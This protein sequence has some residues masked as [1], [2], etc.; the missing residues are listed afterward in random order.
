MKLYDA[1]K[2][3]ETEEGWPYEMEIRRAKWPKSKKVSI[4][5]QLSGICFVNIEIDGMLEYFYWTPDV[6]DI[7]ADD[8]EVIYTTPEGV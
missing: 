6:Q 8:W 4:A 7:L 5:L 3:A 1:I 2:S